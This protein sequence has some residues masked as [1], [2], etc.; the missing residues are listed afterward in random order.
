MRWA[1]PDFGRADGF[2]RFYRCRDPLEN[3]CGADFIGFSGRADR[4]KS[5]KNRR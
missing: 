2:H 4:T 3:G 1:W 5:V